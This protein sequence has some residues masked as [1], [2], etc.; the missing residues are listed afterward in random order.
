VE[1][2]SAKSL[3]YFLIGQFPDGAQNRLLR[4]LHIN[5]GSLAQ[6]A[7]TTTARQIKSNQVLFRVG[8]V[9]KKNISRSHF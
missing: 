1:L 2:R 3:S 6:H 9:N 5:L 8:V 4:A 7:L